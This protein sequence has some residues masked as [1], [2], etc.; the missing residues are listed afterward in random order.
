M[1]WYKLLA[2]IKRV[3]ASRTCSRKNVL[4]VDGR[5]RREA[6]IAANVSGLG[7]ELRIQRDMNELDAEPDLCLPGVDLP[8]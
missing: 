8:P 3:L 4:V 2:R 5:P 1:F 6:P 7:L